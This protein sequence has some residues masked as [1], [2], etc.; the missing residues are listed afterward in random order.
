M[1]GVGVKTPKMRPLN[2]T[3]RKTTVT[4]L[5]GSEMPCQKRVLRAMILGI[6]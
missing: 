4:G 1:K 2:D 5:A 3:R 6:H